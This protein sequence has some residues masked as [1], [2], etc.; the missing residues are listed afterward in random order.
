MDKNKR[1]DSLSISASAGCG[2]TQEMASR[3][4]GMFLSDID[5]PEKV[6]NSSIAMTFSRSGAKEIYN[7]VL[8]LIF[9]ALLNNGIDNLNQ[10]LQKLNFHVPAADRKTLLNLL[11]KLIFLIND[12][13]ICTIDSFM[14][15]IVTSFST[16]LGLPRRAELTGEGEGKILEANV[17]K[18]LLLSNES[19][20]MQSEDEMR[21]IAMES[22]KNSYGKSARVYHEDIRISVRNCKKIIDDYPNTEAYQSNI[23][24]KKLFPAEQLQAAW[25]ILKDIPIDTHESCQTRYNALRK[26]STAELDTF[27][28]SEE[29]ESMRKYFDRW[30]KIK[31]R[32][33][34]KIPKIKIDKFNEDECTA[35]QILLLY[36][37]YILLNQ[38]CIRSEGALKLYRN[39]QKIYAESFYSKGKMTFSDL[40]RILSNSHNDW[41]YDIAYRLNNRFS[42]YL[43]D[44][45]QDTSQMQWHILNSIFGTPDAED[46]KS[47]FIVGDSKQA[48]YGWRSGDRRPMGEA[49]EN[50]KTEID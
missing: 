45:F 19:A 41:T 8:E 5:N 42:H 33:Y 44:E 16:E 36:G 47:I 21:D 43:I 30:D 2:K 40:P 4:L 10:S 48:I 26:I 18:T 27:F 31:N 9:D 46:D 32:D 37:A 49:T 23:D 20:Q 29:L 28:N 35:L 39:Y 13:K 38:S 12:L 17:L 3:L 7:R 50:T 15:K 25:D 1:F 24:V 14:A 22:K 34:G 6:F 11:R